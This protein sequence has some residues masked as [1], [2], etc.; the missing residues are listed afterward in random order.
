M[1]W[2]PIS[3]LGDMRFEIE[4]M[5]ISLC[6]AASGTAVPENPTKPDKAERQTVFSTVW[7]SAGS[8]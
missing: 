5:G 4:V 6:R 8:Y 3:N 7:R 1:V 2:P